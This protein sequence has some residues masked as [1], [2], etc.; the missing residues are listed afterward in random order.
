MT[1][2]YEKKKK[3]NKANISASVSD[4]DLLCYYVKEF[5]GF[6]KPIHSNLRSNDKKSKSMHF[7]TGATGRAVISDF[8]YKKGINIWNY[9]LEYLNYP[10]NTDGF[11]SLLD[12]IREDFKLDLECYTKRSIKV[13]KKSKKEPI[14]HGKEFTPS[15]DWDIRCRYRAWNGTYDKDFWF[16]RYGISGDLLQSLNIKPL[17]SFQLVQGDKKIQYLA[18]EKNPRYAYVPHPDLQISGWKRKIYSPKGIKDK[19]F[20]S[21]T[22]ET[23]LAYHLLPAQGKYLIIETSLKDT[24]TNLQIFKDEKNYSFL[25][26]FSE[27]VWFS[28]STWADLRSRFDWI[29]LHGDNDEP[30]RRMARMHFEDNPELDGWFCNPLKEELKDSS[31]MRWALGEKACKE[32]I[33]NTVETLTTETWEIQELESQECSEQ[34]TNNGTKLKQ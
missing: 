11:L 33:V 5:R 6:G 13:A 31:D 12:T 8:G 14:I 4:Y 23:A 1:F 19:W 20:N 26:M 27:S 22:Q 28:K 7:I 34:R 16:G 18:S 15:R 24:A 32:F 21:L 10:D 29:F 17:D 25:D 2:N 9:L 30:G 3:L